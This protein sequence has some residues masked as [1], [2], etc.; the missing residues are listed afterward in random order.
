MNLKITLFLLIILLCI[1][2]KSAMAINPETAGNRVSLSGYIK[3]SQN[4]E[5]LIG[6]TII[7]KELKNGTTTNLYGFYSINLPKGNYNIEIT[8]VGFKT[9]SSKVNLDENKVLNIEL[10]TDAKELEEVVI[11]AEKP[12]A[13][14][15][16]TEMSVAKL[17]MKTIKKI[18]ALMG[19]VDVIKAIQLLPGVQS[20]SE[21]SSGFSVRGG[22]TDQNLI[23]LDEATVYNASHLLGFF[24]VFNND[25]I[26]EIKLYKGDIPA[27]S[28]GRLSS[29]L[30]VRMKDGNSKEFAGT[31][32]IGLISSRLAV[33]GPIIKDKASFIVS[34][35][36]TYADLFFPLLPEEGAQDASLYFYDLNL[37][38]N[39]IV[40]QNNRVYISGYLGK[41]F[42]GSGDA[43]FGFGNNTLTL[44]W[45]HQYNSILFSNLTFI[46]S[47]Y[48]YKIENDD[49]TN[50]FKWSSDLEDY[51]IKLDY[52]LYATPEN[53]IKFG[54]SSTYHT[55]NPGKVTDFMGSGSVFKIHNNYAYEHGIYASNEQKLFNKLTL[56]YGLRYSAFQN[57]SK[58]NIYKY[59]NE[60][61]IYDTITNPPVKTYS[62]LEPRLGFT[63]EIDSISSIKGSY[64]YTTQYVQLASNSNAGFPLDVWYPASN[65]VKP[66][67][68]NQYAIGY[69]RN[70]RHNTIETSVEVYY[71]D[72]YNV[73]DFKDNA[74]LLL[75]SKLEGELR[76]GKAY[77][78]GAEFMIQVSEKKLN[79]WVSYTYSRTKRKVNDISKNNWYVAPYDKPHNVAIV[80]NYEFTKRL[81]ISANW[82]YATGTPITYPIYKTQLDDK[83][84]LLY[85]SGRNG[86]RLPDYHRLD[87]ALIL[88][89]K[90]KPNALWEGEWNFS[91]YNA[92]AHKNVWMVN[93][94]QD[95]DN[96]NVLNGE[97]TYL[98]S[99]VPSVTY[100]FKF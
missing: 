87:L 79:G 63:F 36:R 95:K 45:N 31:G 89:S 91:L 97:M 37:K 29:L 66:Q 82:V 84:W 58:Q 2:H 68:A 13:N 33:E 7:V 40:N 59:D 94:V 77:S 43:G 85:Y 60:F 48:N 51:S 39:Y 19:E 61:K 34:G 22:S 76:Y 26:K 54:A 12:D 15:K 9:Y 74:V 92:Y 90:H 49:N 5:A 38:A 57:I 46:K 98:F 41:D 55:F 20:T 70:F 65:N 18:P 67:K 44:R 32:G 86:S 3:D 6:A 50:T 62:A 64:S 25:V 73:I 75:N 71:K 27:S 69:F 88:K 10:L 99:V 80:L 47:N 28:G 56:K 24:S 16:R 52:N 14:V 21:G 17:E 11:Q 1:Q 96:P 30:D 72:M 93:F 53:T 23:L 8:Y 78:Y 42:F 83:T 100:N 35:R 81:S 4:G